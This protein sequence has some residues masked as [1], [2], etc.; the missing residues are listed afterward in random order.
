MT[1]SIDKTIHLVPYP[2]KGTISKS[3][4]HAVMST[5]SLYVS[6]ELGE[7]WIDLSFGK[8]QVNNQY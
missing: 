6:D 4:E 5:T 1:H 7:E 2:S 8:L 3:A